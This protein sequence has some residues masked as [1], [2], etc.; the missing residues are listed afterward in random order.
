MYPQPKPLSGVMLP[1]LAIAALGSVLTVSRLNASR[2]NERNLEDLVSAKDEIIATVSHELRTPLTGVVGFAVELEAW[3]N[4]QGDVDA[5]E[6]IALVVDEA[7]QAA[8]LVDDL[9]VA[10]RF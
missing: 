3:V 8:C 10:A 6:L 7:Q 9:L 5:D 4:T 1:I 2:R